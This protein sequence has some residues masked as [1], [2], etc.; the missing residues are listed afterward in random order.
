MS[1]KPQLIIILFRTKTTDLTKKDRLEYDCTPYNLE[2]LPKQTIIGYALMTGRVKLQILSNH[3]EYLKVPDAISLQQASKQ[4]SNYQAHYI[5]KTHWLAQPIEAKN[6]RHRGVKFINFN[7][8][9]ITKLVKENVQI[10]M[11]HKT[12]RIKYAILSMYQ[13]WVKEIQGGNKQ[14]LF[15][16]PINQI[17]MRNSKWVKTVLTTPQQQRNEIETIIPNQPD[18]N[19]KRHRGKLII[20]YIQS[21][22]RDMKMYI[23]THTRINND[24]SAKTDPI[25]KHVINH[26]KCYEITE[27]QMFQ[28]DAL[29]LRWKKYQTSFF[30]KF[31]RLPF[32][33]LKNGYTPGRAQSAG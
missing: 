11:Y 10:Q 27:Q 2:K 1:K 14:W 28:A 17:M 16:T 26:L 8:P 32:S 7:H 13:T 25:V 20:D 30:R 9:I 4:I 31:H 15:Q 22:L 6:I 12:Y 3:I 18:H 29:Q 19:R 21:T 5:S 23:A 24:Y 33:Q